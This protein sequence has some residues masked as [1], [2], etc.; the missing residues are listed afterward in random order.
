MIAYVDRNNVG[1]AKLKM[2][3]DLPG[4]SNGVIGFGAGACFFVGYLLLEIPG[5]LLVEKWMPASGSAGSW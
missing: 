1:L 5:S 2:I 3:E 4:F